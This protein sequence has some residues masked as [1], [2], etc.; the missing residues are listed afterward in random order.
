MYAIN[1]NGGIRAVDSED[2]L[3]TGEVFC[4]VLPVQVTSSKD[5]IL[6]EIQELEATVTPRR[7]REALISGDTSYIKSVDVAV[8]KLRLQL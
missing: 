3:E 2:D 7:V 8:S 1:K 6:A 5:T 4:E